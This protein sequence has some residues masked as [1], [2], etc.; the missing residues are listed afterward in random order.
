MTIQLS[1]MK[2]ITLKVPILDMA[3]NSVVRSAPKG[4]PF[5]GITGEIMDILK[6]KT[7]VAAVC[8]TLVGRCSKMK[9]YN[10][11]Q[12]MGTEDYAKHAGVSRQTI[13]TWLKMGLIKNAYRLGS[14]KNV[15]WMIL[16]PVT[17]NP[18]PGFFD[19]KK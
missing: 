1:Y 8:K 6:D 12:V 17:E 18:V 11:T 10:Y 2:H 15:K 16:Q 3:L 14:G 19:K 5:D 4:G 13:S 9:D 7:I